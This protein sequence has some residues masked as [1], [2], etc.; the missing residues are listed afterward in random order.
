MTRVCLLV[1]HPQRD[2][3]G[4]VLVSAH[5]AAEGVE[6]FLV[7]MYQKQ[8][9]WLLAP[10]LVLV[11]YLRHAHRDF[12]LTCLAAGIRVGVLD[13]EGGVRDFSGFSKQVEP[14]LP[15]MSLYCVWGRVQFDALAAAA[16]RHR[17]ALVETGSPRDDF[18]VEP[19]IG[20]IPDVDVPDGPMVLVNTNFPLVNSRFQGIEAEIQEL[21]KVGWKEAVVR[22]RVAQ[23]YQVRDA[24]L[25]AARDLAGQFPQATVVVRPHP[26]ENLQFYEEEFRGI[27]NI[28]ARQEGTIFQWLK[29]SAA[30]VHNNCSTAI[31]AA[32]MGREP[33]MVDW[34]DAPLVYQEATA[35]VSHRARSREELTAL[36]ARTT[37]GGRIAPTAE[38]EAAR[39]EI[40][41][42]F[43][44]ANDGHAARRVAA[45]IL[46]ATRAPAHRPALSTY[47]RRVLSTPSDLASRAQRAILVAGGNSVY[48][49]VQYLA[50]RSRRFD[51]K[52]F[53]TEEVS[54]VLNRLAAVHPAWQRLRARTIARDDL[55]IGRW[56]GASSVRVAA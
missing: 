30:L 4:L 38:L 34:I 44:R 45:A 1:D 51:D 36:V 16:E 31:E 13:T 24:V 28:Q 52:T 3:D 6:V 56:G 2:L 27:R 15:G 53:S 42:R 22:S 20:A 9:V 11:N 46:E 25:A 7:P 37:A 10:D 23:T 19:W 50:R 8:E 35:A 21:V 39:A 14:Y 40:I 17:L 41:E 5:L 26:F 29:R 47:A 33:V 48:R 12:L 55:L 43:F 32:M 54:G 18:A 49:R